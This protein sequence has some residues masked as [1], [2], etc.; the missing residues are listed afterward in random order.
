MLAQ[1]RAWNA[2]G[3][4]PGPALMAIAWFHVNR[5]AAS[6]DETDPSRSDRARER[7]YVVLARCCVGSDWVPPCWIRWHAVWDEYLTHQDGWP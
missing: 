6:G 7:A 2:I 1:R 4:F 3:A 5:D